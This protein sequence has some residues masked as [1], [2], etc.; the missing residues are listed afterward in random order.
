MS[1]GRQ[2]LTDVKRM[3]VQ[4][5]KRE[6]DIMEAILQLNETDAKEFYNWYVNHQGVKNIREVIKVV[7]RG[8][9]G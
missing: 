8:G 9:N 3:T 4:H 1:N 7:G 6:L 5:L 2:S